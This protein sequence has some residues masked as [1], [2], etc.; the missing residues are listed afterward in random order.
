MKA[1]VNQ[2]TIDSNKDKDYSRNREISLNGSK[3]NSQNALHW[4]F[5]PIIEDPY[6]GNVRCDTE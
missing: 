6:K 4:P 2:D 3:V 1:N 5:E